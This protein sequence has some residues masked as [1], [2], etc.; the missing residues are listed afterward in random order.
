MGKLHY[1][2]GTEVIY[3][4]NGL[5]LNQARYAISLLDR[6]HM[7]NCKPISTPLPPNHRLHKIDNSTMLSDIHSFRSI[8]GAL[9][10]FT[11]TRTR[12]RML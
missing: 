5:F 11:T 2:L 3:Q 7:T 4:N 10:Y 6:E 12:L 9:R 8:D 1:L